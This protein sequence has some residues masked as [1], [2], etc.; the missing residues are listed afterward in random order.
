M[1]QKIPGSVDGDMK[2]DEMLGI[3]W[4][5]AARTLTLPI[6]TIGPHHLW[7]P[8]HQYQFQL[9]WPLVSVVTINV[10]ARHYV[11][12]SKENQPFIFTD[13]YGMNVA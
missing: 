12:G 3:C 10:Q 13:Y 4:F 1:K 11:H 7:A 2:S 5:K 6:K 9:S 8:P